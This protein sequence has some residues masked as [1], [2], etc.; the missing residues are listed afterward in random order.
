MRKRQYLVLLLVVLLALSATAA[1]AAAS[2]NYRAH[3]SGGPSGTDSQ[4]QGQAIFQFSKDGTELSYKLILANIENVTQAHIHIAPAPG[5]NGPIALWLLPDGPPSQLIPG[6]SDGVVA[7]RTVT[8]ADLVGPLA[9]MTFDDLRAAIADGL[10]YVNVHTSQ[11]PGGEIRG[12]I[13]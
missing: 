13:Q 12:D 2:R 7:E 9:G 8:A 1:G 6:R 3:L 4:G 10:A 11:F 5:A